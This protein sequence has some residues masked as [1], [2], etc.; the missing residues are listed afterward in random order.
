MV[1]FQWHRWKDIVF[2]VVTDKGKLVLAVGSRHIGDWF[3]EQVEL[4][5]RAQI[6]LGIAEP[7]E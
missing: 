1:G 4:A 3:K 2:T 5:N 7:L 6:K